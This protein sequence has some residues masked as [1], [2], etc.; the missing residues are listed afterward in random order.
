MVNL[1]IVTKYN[2]G[3]IVRVK[4]DHSGRWFAKGYTINFTEGKFY[5][6]GVSR[7]LTQN[8]YCL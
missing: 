5:I 4:K 7:Q 6:I 8:N 3:D 2:V 1:T